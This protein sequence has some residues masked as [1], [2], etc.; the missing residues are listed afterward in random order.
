M[1]N[2]DVLV[3]I[4]KYIGFDNN[5]SSLVSSFL[6]D[7]AQRVVL[8]GQKSD[9]QNIS[10]GVPQGSILGPL[11]FITVIHQIFFLKV[12]PVAPIHRRYS[13]LQVL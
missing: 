4:L 10:N 1:L 5:A 8:D 3:A 11:L 6:S 12:Y 9:L 7:R 13:N 2:H